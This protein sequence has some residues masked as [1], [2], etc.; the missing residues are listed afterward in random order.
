MVLTNYAFAA[1]IVVAVR[2]HSG[3]KKAIIQWQPTLKYLQQSLPGY[4]FTLLPVKDI[5]EM[6]EKVASNQIDFVITQPVAYV[7]LE[8]RYKATRLLTLQKQYGSV[9]GSVIFTRSD[10]NDINILD[11][12]KGKDI[13]GVTPNGFGGWLIG[14]NELLNH[15]IDT[16]KVCKSVDYLG[17]HD[18]VVKAVMDGKIDVGIVRTGIIEKMAATKEID[19]ANI[20]ILNQQN[21]PSFPLLLSSDLY[22]EWAFAKTAKV[23]ETIAKEV[24]I[25]LLAMPSNHIAAQKGRYQ[26]WTIP[27]TYQPVHNLMQ[28][29]RVGSYSEYGK[30]N[31]VES[32]SQHL[33]KIVISLCLLFIAIIFVV[34]FI[35]LKKSEQALANEQEKLLVTLRS[36]GDGVITTDLDGK[37]V[38]INKVTEQ[39]TGWNHQEAVGKPIGKV[40]NI[41]N[42]K[43]GDPC[44]NPVDKV[45]A[46]GKIIDLKNHTALVAR[47]GTH[48]IIKDSGAPI[49]N[50][51]SEIIGVVLV[52]RDVTK[53]RRAEEELLKVKKLESVGILAGGIAH[54]F[55]NILAAILGNIELAEMS[56]NSTEEAYPLLQEAKKASIRAKDLT[57]QLLTFSKGGAP[58]KKTT[59]IEK[60]I[61]ESANFVLHGSSVSCLFNIPHDLWLVDIDSGQ[62]SQVIQNLVINAKQAMPGGGK[63][64]IDC[65]NIADIKSDHKVDLPNKAYIKIA[66]QDNGCG[67]AEK[68]LK[69]IFDPYFTTKQEGSGLGLAISYS[70]I[71]KHDGFIEVKSVS[72]EGTTFSI[73][74]PASREQVRKNPSK[75]THKKEVAKA[76]ILVMDDDKLVQDIAK[77][78][79][80]RLGHK[81]LLAGDGK[82]AIK[83]FTKHYNSGKPVDVII[84]DLTIPGGMGGKDALQEVLK[85]DPKVKAI[86]SS[87]YSNDPIMSNCRHYGFK[88]A[89]AKPFMMSE[90]TKVLTEVLG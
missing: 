50:H 41:I 63:I 60:V 20:K 49:F 32:I 2:A 28:Q 71:S 16:Y 29:L 76:R 66:V 39:L 56:I 13:A 14:Y 52:Y 40:F 46:T 3:I 34:K 45:L 37:I 69:K 48:Y 73:Y 38:L 82:E 17:T 79:I 30:I 77:R 19:P 86:V 4:H 84:M 23:S 65:T 68:Y 83:I 61:I 78:M 10:R 42:E 43:T 6:E 35:F 27:L 81:V 55:N 33:Y 72:G 67:M 9:F 1:N 12:I 44:D 70:I 22:P 57:L 75:P 51:K 18:N 47:D 26:Q 80:L 88:A 89:M 31:V 15:G 59:P 90:L 87:G 85:I 53:E 5:K 21:N 25:A 64:K 7:D 54:D 8:R 11:D 24:A 58:V 74:L 62:I 36:M